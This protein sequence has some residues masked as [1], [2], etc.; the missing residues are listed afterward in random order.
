MST[1]HADP[2]D[3]WRKIE[4]IAAEVERRLPSDD[5]SWSDP[6]YVID[7]HIAHKLA[8]AKL[9]AAFWRVFR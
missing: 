8:V 4:E 9:Y 7:R 2:A 6:R 3:L 1:T 5:G